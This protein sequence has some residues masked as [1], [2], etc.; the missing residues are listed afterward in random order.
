[1]KK[2]FSGLIPLL[3]IHFA[4]CDNSKAVT[5]KEYLKTKE[6]VDKRFIPESSSRLDNHFSKY[7]PYFKED[8]EFWINAFTLDSSKALVIRE[9]KKNPIEILDTI[10]NPLKDAPVIDSLYQVHGKE[11][12]TIRII[13]GR[14]QRAKRTTLRAFEHLDYIIDS[15]EAYSL[16]SSLAALPFFESGFNKEAGSKK[17][18]LGIWQFRKGTARD[19]GLE[20]NNKID[21]RK[22]PKKSLIAAI[23]YMKKANERFDS[24]LLALVSYNTGLYNKYFKDRKT[25]TDIEIVKNMGYAPRQYAPSF[26]ASLEILKDPLKYYS[27][28]NLKNKK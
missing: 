4:R 11:K 21:E 12:G 10:K 27:D 25:K 22:D 28:L 3:F 13:D 14:K 20:V 15:L 26:L 24:D 2:I 9:S 16:P 1:M 17:Y 7:E 6:I 5:P 8:K 18:A 23:K 19:F